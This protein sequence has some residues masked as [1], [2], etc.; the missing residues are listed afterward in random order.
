MHDRLGH[1][2]YFQTHWNK[3]KFNRRGHICT[4]TRTKASK[5]HQI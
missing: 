3:F 1:R 4:N 5:S 2:E